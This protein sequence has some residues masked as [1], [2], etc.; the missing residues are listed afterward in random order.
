MKSF[1]IKGRLFLSAI[2]VCCAYGCSS[3]E[4]DTPEEEIEV[5]AD[6]YSRDDNGVLIPLWYDMSKSYILFDASDQETVLNKLIAM[7]I[8]VNESMVT[9][10]G[11]KETEDSFDLKTDTFF[12]M[13][14]YREI[15]SINA[16]YETLYQIPEIVYAIPN[17]TDHVRGSWPWKS[18]VFLRTEKSSELAQ[19][20]NDYG[21]KIIGK[22]KVP[23]GSIPIWL[24][25]CTK[26]SKG[27][28]SEILDILVQLKITDG[29]YHFKTW[30]F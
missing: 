25:C 15:V 29:A 2:I 8:D 3:N 22:W 23:E 27:N 30:Y 5:P 19:A 28:T 24:I 26:Y 7:G 14:N 10:M 16:N 6:L 12:E 9:D 21:F 11:L 4:P 20:A 13:L 17:V 1:F 18:T